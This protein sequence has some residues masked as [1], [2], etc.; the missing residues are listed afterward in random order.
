MSKTSLPTDTVSLVQFLDVARPGLDRAFRSMYGREVGAEVLADVEAWAVEHQGRL[1]TMT[2]PVG[3]LFRVGQSSAR[4][5]QRYSRSFAES[6][7]ADLTSFCEFDTD[8]VRVLGHLTLHQR[9]AL[10]LVHGYGWRLEDAATYMNC[11]ISTVRNHL[12]RG[13]RR[14]QRQWK[15]VEDGA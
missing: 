10:L 9:T 2:N 5:Y 12:R 6:L 7:N 15:G 4:K 13:E 14:V 3:Y 8:L 11:S 1:L